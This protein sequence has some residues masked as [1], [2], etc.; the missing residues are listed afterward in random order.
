MS[1]N[2]DGLS[3]AVVQSLRAADG[4]VVDCLVE[5]LEPRLT[6]RARRMTSD[7]NLVDELVQRARVVTAFAVAEYDESK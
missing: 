5:E 6:R 4:I 1:K 3:E 2:R 7:H